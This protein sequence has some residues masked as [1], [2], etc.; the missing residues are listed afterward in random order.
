MK[1]K[2]SIF[3]FSINFCSQMSGDDVTRSSRFNERGRRHND[4]ESEEDD[5]T[6][7]TS[8]EAEEDRE[9]IQ[10]EESHRVHG[11]LFCGKLNLRWHRLV[12][13]GQRFGRC[14]SVTIILS[15]QNFTAFYN[16]NRKIELA[17][18]VVS[19]LQL[20]RFNYFISST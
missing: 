4:A 13:V 12:A 9:E 14:R 15:L 11:P 2:L 6:S 20:Q 1:I 3:L 8:S 17:K 7:T 19:S 18:H 5:V 10:E 16:F